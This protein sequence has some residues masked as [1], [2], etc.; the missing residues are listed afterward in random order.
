[1]C[2]YKKYIAAKGEEIVYLHV[3]IGPWTL[4]IQG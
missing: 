2:H 3:L 1:M 4:I